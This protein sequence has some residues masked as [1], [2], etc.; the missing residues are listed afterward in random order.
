MKL[1]SVMLDEQGERI[2]FTFSHL[3]RALPIKTGIDGSWYVVAPNAVETHSL[4]K[5]IKKVNISF[6]TVV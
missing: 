3:T 4:I 2:Y 1:L 5:H 6:T